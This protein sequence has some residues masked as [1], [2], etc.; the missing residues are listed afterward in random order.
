MRIDAAAAKPPARTRRTRVDRITTGWMLLAA[1]LL[2]YSQA[3]AGSVPQLW[4][5]TVHLVTLGVVAN[6][7]LQWSWY[8]TRSLLR[9]APDSRSAGAHQTARQLLFNIAVVGLLGSMWGAN[10]PAAVV[11]AGAIGVVIVWYVVALI[12]V[13]RAALGARFAVI[14]RY[15]IAAG[16]MLVFGAIYGALT[17]VPLLG[18]GDWRALVDMQNGLTIAHSLL[19]GLGFVGLTIAGTLVTLGPTA[20]R[21]RM[22]PDAVSRAVAALPVL[23]VG[24]V[25]AALAATW[26]F[27]P[28]AGAFVLIYTVALIW[29]VGVGLFH[30]AARK[31]MG[32]VATW[33]FTVG[34]LWSLVGL[35]WLAGALMF[36]S[37][38]SEFRETARVVVAAIGVGGV[39][40]ILIG[41]L[42]YLLP[43]VVGGGPA[44]VR[45]GIDT[46]ESGGG[47]RIAAR[48][49][50]LAMAVLMAASGAVPVGP[51]A[52]VVG[53]TYVL[54]IVVFAVAGVRQA[55]RKR[56][57]LNQRAKEETHDGR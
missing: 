43:V 6:A 26:E 20:L 44:V 33:N 14:V 8:F 1:A 32:E 40:Q 52:A 19:N 51:F 9:L 4:W 35:T 24:V 27:F 10:A 55:K 38:A 21:T 57:A 47:F 5:T 28:P 45:V 34:V 36:A 56:L 48:N 23:V 22:D 41:A 42:S 16:V 13:S 2:I 50:A 17:V 3:F 11:F 37:S 49:A 53:A 31:P 25:G 7:I 18:Q 15:Y 30:A 39:L 46:V 54:D 12:L 29:G